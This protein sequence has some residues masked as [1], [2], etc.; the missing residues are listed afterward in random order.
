MS[1][2]LMRAL[3]AR[4]VAA[5]ARE[6]GASIPEGFPDNLD[7]FLR[8]RLAQLDAD[9]TI[10]SWLARAMV[11]TDEDGGR[12][13]IGTIGFHGAP[14]D[15]GRLEV[16][17]RIE[18]EYRRRGFA[19]EAV[20]AMLDWAANERGIH[21]FIAS[22]RPDNDASLGLAAGFGFAQTGTQMDD[23]DGLEL[24]LEATWPPASGRP[25]RGSD[26]AG[27]GLG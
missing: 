22:I 23:I 14:D 21:R 20:R 18:P 2:P 9:P 11:L 19:R 6:I 27:D 25:A 15:R 7:H 4:D 10:L 13:V 5:T 24:V 12:R 16:G 3:V 26:P 17:Y 8:C 1:I